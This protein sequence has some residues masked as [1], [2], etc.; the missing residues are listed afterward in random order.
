V[1]EPGIIATEF[2]DVMLQGISKFSGRGAYAG[3]TK[4][5]ITAT[6]KMYDKGQGSKPSVIADTVSKIVSDPRP[7][8]RY[9]VGYLAKPMVWIR[10]F[11]GDRIFDKIVMSQV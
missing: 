2:G 11:L 8:T 3:L 9:R 7:K 1:L 6:K 4:K 10:V 5:L